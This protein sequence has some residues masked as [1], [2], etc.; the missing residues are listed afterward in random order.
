MHRQYLRQKAL[1]KHQAEMEPIFD[2]D[3]KADKAGNKALAADLWD[4]FV[5]MEFRESVG[6]A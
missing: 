2:A 5:R 6:A 1:D 4:K 3:V